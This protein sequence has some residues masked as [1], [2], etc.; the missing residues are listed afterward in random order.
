MYILA[1]AFWDE[2]T[3]ENSD[4][5]HFSWVLPC[6]GRY[7]SSSLFRVAAAR[8]CSKVPRHVR[9]DMCASTCAPR[10]V[11]LYTKDLALDLI[12]RELTTRDLT[13]VCALALKLLV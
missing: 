8:M 9:L 3:Y 7:A 13:S 6:P 5:S 2:E 11:C 10:R 12:C 1:C 4:T